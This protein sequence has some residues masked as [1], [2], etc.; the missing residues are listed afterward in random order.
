[1]AKLSDM[2]NLQTAPLNVTMVKKRWVVLNVMMYV[3]PYF[4][5]TTTCEKIDEKYY[6]WEPPI[7]TLLEDC[8]K[9]SGPNTTCPPLDPRVWKCTQNGEA[10]S[11]I[12]NGVICVLECVSGVDMVI[13]ER[14]TC[15]NGGWTSES[16]RKV[17]DSKIQELE[18]LCTKNKTVDNKCPILQG[19]DFLANCTLNGQAMND[20][21][22]PSHNTE[23]NLVCK[24]NPQNIIMRRLKCL[25]NNQWFWV[26]TVNL[27]LIL[28]S[29]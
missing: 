1:M 22:L 23:C 5:Q 24:N 11:N 8:N 3:K 12:Q 2:K 6:Q 18:K 27:I 19:D 15:T 21:Q 26:C 28:K 25:G 7:Q 9:P 17:T 29:I 4:I 14:L 16:Y 20:K 10:S 13:Y